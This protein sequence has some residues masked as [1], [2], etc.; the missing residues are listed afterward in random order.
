MSVRFERSPIPWRLLPLVVIGGA[1]GALARGLLTAPFGVVGESDA[2]LVALVVVNA[3]G[4]GLLGF[5]TGA[6]AARAEL[7]ALLGA[8][9]LGGFTSYSALAPVLALWPLTAPVAPGW[10]VVEAL[11]AVVVLIAVPVS[12]AAAGLGLGRRRA[13]GRG[14]R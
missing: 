6:F 4:S 5:V 11:A 10:A 7:Q 3:V 8:G 2:A 1:L 14:P 13:R 9:A 12:A